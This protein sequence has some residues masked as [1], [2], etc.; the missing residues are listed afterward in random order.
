MEIEIGKSTFRLMVDHKYRNVTSMKNTIVY[1]MCIDKTL[2]YKTIKNYFIQTIYVFLY[3]SILLLFLSLLSFI[4][5]LFNFNINFF[6]GLSIVFLIPS[7]I[8]C[9]K[10]FNLRHTAKI[11]IDMTFNFIQIEMEILKKPE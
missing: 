10:F 5:I 8:Y 1:E 6:S 7:F 9:I 3:R 11:L 2:A 4:P